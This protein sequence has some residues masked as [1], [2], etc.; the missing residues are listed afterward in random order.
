MT[1]FA[2]GSMRMTLGPTVV[3]QVDTD[4]TVHIGGAAASQFVAPRTSWTRLSTI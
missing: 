1:F 3:I 2:N 4:K